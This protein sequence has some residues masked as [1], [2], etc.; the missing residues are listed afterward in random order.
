MLLHYVSIFFSFLHFIYSC[1]ILPACVENMNYGLHYMRT[2][3]YWKTVNEV[4]MLDFHVF[5]LKQS[6]SFFFLTDISLSSNLKIIL[7]Y[8]VK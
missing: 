5:P 8:A 7:Y 4:I 3:T 6:Q 1:N 2:I